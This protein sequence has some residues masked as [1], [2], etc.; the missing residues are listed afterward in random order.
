MAALHKVAQGLGKGLPRA[1]MRAAI[2]WATAASGRALHR[3]R[4]GGGGL[5]ALKR[6]P[7]NTS[8]R[9]AVD[10]WGGATERASRSPAARRP[11]CQTEQT[12]SNARVRARR[13]HLPNTWQINW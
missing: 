1:R 8:K 5:C 11:Y 13:M 7:R 2:S 6:L 9:P 3:W 4:A 10:Q 12:A